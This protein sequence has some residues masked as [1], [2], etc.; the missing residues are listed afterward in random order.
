MTLTSLHLT[1]L[2]PLVGTLFLA[3]PIPYKVAGWINMLITAFAFLVS[4]HL[5]QTVLFF[6][7]QLTDDKLFYV[8]AFNV[9]LIVLTTFVGMNTAIF[10]RP[11]MKYELDHGRLTLPRMR[12]Y[13]AMYQGF[14]F[15]M[16][17]ALMSNNL[18]LLWVAMEAATLATVL[19]VS[20][21]RTPES[22]EAAW[23][24]FILCGVGIA[25]A[26]FGTVPICATRYSFGTGRCTR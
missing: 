23:K 21:Y 17:L 1:L 22:I 9:Y 11:Y 13:H 10:S 18:G 25:Q 20:L 26:L 19:L 4:L 5:A 3:L 24:Y 2:V 12:I 14:I 16:L 7:A 6:G 8:D 15:A